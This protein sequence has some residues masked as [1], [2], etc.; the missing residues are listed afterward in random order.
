MLDNMLTYF[1]VKKKSGID[2][3]ARTRGIMKLEIGIRNDKS[4]YTYRMSSFWL[5]LL[6]LFDSALVKAIAQQPLVCLFSVILFRHLCR[7]MLRLFGYVT[8][9]CSVLLLA[10]KLPTLTFAEKGTADRLLSW[11]ICLWLAHICS[12]GEKKL[13]TLL[14]RRNHSGT[15]NRTTNCFF[16]RKLRWIGSFHH[17][18]A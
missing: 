15:K 6:L 12:L 1:P 9:D 8:A 5:L 18:P 3:T 10:K 7:Y 16:F 13:R 2:Y 4:V 11:Q 14:P 17:S